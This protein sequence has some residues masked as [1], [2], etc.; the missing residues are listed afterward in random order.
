MY[1]GAAEPCLDCKSTAA[2]PESLSHLCFL[3][4]HFYL[5]LNPATK[6]H[7]EDIR[8][9]FLVGERGL[10]NDMASIYRW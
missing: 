4:K 6:I 2:K 7:T 10:F 1:E 9:L 8:P 3:L 5:G